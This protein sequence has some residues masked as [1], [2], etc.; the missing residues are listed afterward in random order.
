MIN[1]INPELKDCAGCICS[2]SGGT[3]S[4]GTK[5]HP[6]ASD[7]GNPRRITNQK[8]RTQL[9]RFLFGLIAAYT[10]FMLGVLLGVQI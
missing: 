10:A 8:R 4:M 6:Y 1:T 7:Y 2:R 3:H 5:Q 9:E